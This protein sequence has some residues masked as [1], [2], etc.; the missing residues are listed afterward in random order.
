MSIIRS[1]RPILLA[2]LVAGLLSH[3]AAMQ[4]PSSQP[5]V[6]FTNPPANE[7]DVSRD[8][9]IAADVFVPNGGID[10]ATLTSESVYLVRSSDSASVP[11][12]LN[13]SAGGDVIVLRPESPLAA[14]TEYTFVVTEQLQDVAGVG[15][16][17]FSMSFTTGT[18]ATDPDTSV[19][20]ERIQIPGTVAPPEN[21]TGVAMGPDGKVYAGTLNG[22]IYRF[23][24]NA[25]GTLADRQLID[26]IR[27]AHGADRLLVGLEFDKASTESAPIL[28]VSHSTAGLSGVADWGGKISRLTGPN[29][30]TIVDL[31]VNL[32][33]SSRDHVTNQ[34]DIGP[35]GA[36]YF[37]QGSTSAMGA[38]DSAWGYRAEHLLNA[39][40][41]RLDL[42]AIGSTEPFPATIDV[43]T[44]DGGSYDPFAAGAPLTI[45]AT[46]VRN[47]FDL[48]WHR[49]GHLYVPTNGSASG[50]STPSTPL[51]FAPPYLPRIDAAVN[52]PYEGPAVPGLTNVFQTLNDYLYDIVGGGYYGHP[53]PARHEYVMNG[54]NP[55]AN[56]DPA[57]VN[58]Y[59]I[60]VLP[61]RNWRGFAYDFG[62]HYS[63]NGITEYT[64]GAFGG[65][66]T[67]KLLV[68]RYSG[69]DDV[70]VLTPGAGGNIIQAQSGIPGLT[71]YSDPLDV[72]ED[73]AT[74]N[75]YLVEYGGRRM[76]LLRPIVP[77]AAPDN[78]TAAAASSGQV[79]LSW[80]DNSA[81]ETGFRLD[82]SLNGV[83][84]VEVAAPAAGVTAYQDVGV[85]PS[86]TYIYRVRAYNSA[87][88]SS[89]SGTATV[90]T[91][92]GPPAPPPPPA[93]TGLRG[94]Y[95]VNR[96]LTTLAATRVD[97]TV[98]FN[99]GRGSPDPA[100]GPDTFS[101]RWSGQVVPAYS[102][103]Y[104]F[105]TT[106]DDGVRLWVNG[107]RIINNWTDHAPREDRGTID[108]IADQ[109]VSLVME[110]FE[111]YGGA[112]AQLRWS[113]G[114]QPKT[115]IPQERLIPSAGTSPGA[116]TLQAENATIA[117][118][119]VSAIHAG[120]TGTG[121]VDYVNP[122]GDYIEW[123]HGAPAAGMYSI[124]IRYA[125]GGSADRPLELRV[126]GSVVNSHVSFPPTGIWPNWTTV[127]ASVPLVA[128][129]N[130]I[131][132]TAVGFSG[133]NIDA[134]T[135]R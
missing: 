93:G 97:A 120:F 82:R 37:V 54:G 46:G 119:V 92:D 55:T 56:P 47:A 61:D 5:S 41:L 23:T 112:V 85:S 6:T 39:A 83:D 58:Q 53:N 113:S 122:S 118:A 34:L 96:N 42:A 50:G 14:N 90:T 31:V 62:Q 17:P 68:V 121:F 1:L 25:D 106:S 65:A 22:R 98:D 27:L 87:G 70:L 111:S 44:E 131:R 102:E 52:G 48:V 63:P 108:L 101:V 73:P 107:V 32:P 105:F 104:T 33:R 125:N 3:G 81:N 28:Y 76:F 103:T 51:S 7:I 40:V 45:H 114:R 10:P 12:V 43:K 24:V 19:A 59:P 123:I 35:D 16:Q 64:S 74:G 91:P 75:L 88:A 128:G 72:T 20:F 4:P 116:T 110:F 86:T 100:L 66:L 94:E 129:P 2:V 8:A 57:Q 13:T 80:N 135:I 71:G 99:W 49:N 126:N 89:P 130:A 78:L 134:V 36:L 117:G 132:L 109:P 18:A 69:G 9:F 79:D 124:E 21:Y 15:F 26:T 84:F 11:S 67:G 29:L 38:P 95:F 30:E 77:P 133:P 127:S 115:I 60:G